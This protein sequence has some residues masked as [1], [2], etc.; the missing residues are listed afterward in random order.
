MKNSKTI[1]ITGSGSGFGWDSAVALAKRGHR[2]IATTRTEESCQK[3]NTFAEDN[4]LNIQSFKLD[5]TVPEDRQ[6]IMDY[7]IDILLNNAGVG[8]SGSLAEIPLDKIRHNFEVNV[9]GSIALTQL[10]LQ[11]M[12]PRDSGTILFVSSLGGRITMPFM[13]AYAM[14]KFALCGGVDAMRQ[15]IRRITENVHVALIEPG[16]YHTG[17]N[18]KN[19]AKQFVWMDEKS[20]FFKIKDALRK[21]QEEKFNMFEVQSTKSAIKQIVKACEANNPKLRYTAPWWQ[22]LGVQLLRMVGK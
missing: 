10:A 18:Q 21:G 15:E 6:K 2:V 3:L 19:I 4:N 9:F 22:A 5:V 11:K 1:L 12:I 8:E 20:H 16:A 14:T 13:S 7:D 17:F